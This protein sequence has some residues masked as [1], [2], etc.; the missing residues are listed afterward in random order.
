M[1]VKEEGNHQKVTFKQLETYVMS[2]KSFLYLMS[3]LQVSEKLLEE[4]I[5]SLEL[6]QTWQCLGKP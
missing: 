6:T 5:K 1:E 4:F 2:T 3:A